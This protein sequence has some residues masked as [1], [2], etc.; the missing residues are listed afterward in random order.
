VII[1]LQSEIARISAANAYLGA[2]GI[3]ITAAQ[4]TAAKIRAGVGIAT[5][6]AQSI[7]GFAQGGMVRQSDGPRYTRNPGDSVLIS[8]APGEVVMTREQQ[9]R[10][11]M[12]AGFNV[13]AAAKVPG[14]AVGGVVTGTRGTAL[15]NSPTT[16]RPSPSVLSGIE[17]AA[18]MQAQ[19][20]FV[21]VQE[22]NDVQG[23]VA[24][25]TERATL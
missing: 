22:I 10:A 25:V 11:N 9:R 20:I 4:I 6:L 7:Q 3:P 5:I 17:N 18:R 14:F 19:P 21:K 24:R 8:A 15:V 12:L 16:P 13:F 23:R 2:F 1:S